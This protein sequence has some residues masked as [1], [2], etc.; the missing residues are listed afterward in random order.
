MNQSFQLVSPYAP[1]GDQPQAIEK[2]VQGLEQGK[3]FQ[4][5]RGV[6]GSGKT[7]TVANVIEKI[8][9]PTLVMCHN[10][11]LAAQLYY[12]YKTFFPR[13]AVHYFVSYYDYYQPEAYMPT[14][15]TY[16]DKEAMVND[17]LDRLRHAATAAIL[18][19]R[20]VIIVASVSCIYNIGSPK[21][22]EEQAMKLRLG[23]DLT[24]GSLLA[25]LVKLQYERTPADL[26]RGKFRVR[27]N[28]IEVSPIAGEILYTITL[29]G[30]KV[31]H[32]A[33]LHPVTREIIL[34]PQE[35]LVFPAKHYVTPEPL[36]E[37]AIKA[38][39]EEMQERVKY[40]SAKG[41]SASG[42]KNQGKPL[43]AERIER[44]VRLDLN[45]IKQFGYCHGIENYSRHFDGRLPGE[46]AWS[47]V[48]YFGETYGKENPKS[49]IRNPKQIQN[50]NVQNPKH[51]LTPPLSLR[52]RVKGE[53]DSGWL[54]VIDESHMTVPQMGGMLEGDRARK[55]NL[56][57]FGFRLPSAIDNRPLSFKEIEERMPQTL[58]TSAT[59]GP[60]ELAKSTSPLSPPFKGGEG[61]GVVEQIIRPTGL[62]DPEVTVTPMGVT[63]IASPD[64]GRGEVPIAK[65]SRI[66]DKVGTIPS[67]TK[68]HGIATPPAVLRGARNDTKEKGLATTVASYLTDVLTRIADRIARHERVLIT[69][70]T[71]KMA[72]D[73]ASAFVERGIKAKYLHSDIETLDR[74]KILTEFRQVIFDVFV[75]VNLLR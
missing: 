27:G 17:E 26:E 54:L 32:L 69:T 34:E 31:S 52:E 12:E 18:T 39:R 56:I 22:Y 68:Y 30:Q 48:D 40:F 9:R 45:M 3:Q 73:L 6:T 38:I 33:M 63:V 71:K 42:G 23:Q 8:Q 61:G 64:S 41:G 35:L 53:G 15:D 47:L 13:N 7:F 44:R 46:P 72:E 36:K 74:I 49:E 1:A 43:E 65:R 51:F 55:K 59:P 67:L 29:E 50:P 58:F 28:R 21:T 70:L 20:D 60:Y 4:T 2:L 75:G 25:S 11:T 57:E 14:T 5:L 16:I 19:R 66:L 37:Q 10:K 62:V 24:R